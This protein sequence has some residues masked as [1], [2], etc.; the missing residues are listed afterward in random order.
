VFASLGAMLRVSL[1]RSLADWPIVLAAG[2]IVTISATLLAAGT[3]YTS[4]V[5]VASLHRV[6]ADA[7]VTEA[8]IQVSVR[9]P[10][11]RIDP[12]D[13]T[14]TAELRSGLGEIGGT[15]VRTGRSDS[16][17]LPRPEQG[18]RTALAAVGFLEDLERQA[19][20]LVGAWPTDVEAGANIVPV[21]VSETVAASLGLEVG[22]VIELHGRADATFV[23]RVRVD[24]IFTIDDR[25]A[26]SWWEDEQVLEGVLTSERFVTY[27]PLFTTRV[28]LL[29]RATAGQLSFAWRALPAFDGLDP[30]EIDRVRARVEQLRTG[31]SAALES[32]AGTAVA[33]GLPELLTRTQ[34]S[35]L[36]SRTG[37]LVLVI[38]LTALAAYAVLL[39]AG[40]L[41]EHRR[42]GTALLRSRGAGRNRLTQMAL[43]E[44]IVLAGLA[45]LVA[46]WL[47]AGV[48]RAF[49][50]AGPLADI[51]LRIEAAVDPGA[52]VAAGSSI[53][54]DVPPG[55]LGIARGRQ[56]N[57]DGWADKKRRARQKKS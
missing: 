4:A 37:V 57:V 20:L 17:A 50:S 26:A 22:Q 7:P 55:A 15:V 54:D 49:D 29:G 21:A 11:D 10:P 44:G 24:A 16:F 12:T 1:R 36:V 48:L 3:M 41:V 56:R 13:A 28:N 47:A 23:V 18:G 33:T 43:I 8:N 51:G 46:P 53:T 35:L 40:L 31:M 45:A 38:Q 27:G 30:D 39:S 9:L 42:A 19:T 14:V 5:S 52:Y 6:L 2:L 25:T 34:R 32:D